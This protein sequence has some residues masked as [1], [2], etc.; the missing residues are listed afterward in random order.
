MAMPPKT[1]RKAAEPSAVSAVVEAPVAPA[2]KRPQKAAAPEPVAP[3]K[4]RR[5]PAVTVIE[6]A[7]PAPLAQ[8]KPPARKRATPL[9]EVAPAPVPA[10]KAAPEKST[11]SRVTSKPAAAKKAASKRSSAAPL[12]PAEAAVEAAPPAPERASATAKAA[13]P[14]KLA[15][16]ATSTDEGGR[17]K[18]ATRPASKAASKSAKKPPVK[19]AVKA[20]AKSAAMPPQPAVEADEPESAFI[21]TADPGE[22]LFGAFGMQDRQS[23]QEVQV[24]LRGAA[25]GDYHCSC[26]AFERSLDARCEHSDFLFESL[27]QGG[28]PIQAMLQQGPLTHYSELW[29]AYGAERRLRWRA[30]LSAPAALQAAAAALLDADRSASAEN[31]QLPQHLLQLAA[32]AGHELRVDPLVWSQLAWASD[33]QQRVQR[34]EP[35]FAEGPEG[36]VLSGLLSQPL[37]AYQ[38]EAALFAVCAGRALLADDLGLSQ[39]APA[40]A[41]LRLWQQCFGLGTALLVAPGDRHPLWRAE[42]Q[43]LLG[44]WPEGVTLLDPSELHPDTRCELLIIDAVQQ[45]TLPLPRLPQAPHGLL[46]ADRELLGEASLE[47]WIDW[48]DIARRGPLARLKA[49]GSQPAKRQQ[50]EALQSVMLSR[51]RRDLDAQLPPT[52]ETKVWLDAGVTLDS[53]ALDAARSQLQRWQKLAYLSHADQLQL[54]QS[55]AQLKQVSTSAAACTAKAEAVVALLPQILPA[56]ASR[57]LVAAQD[58]ATLLPVA[59]KLKALGLSVHAVL[60]SQ[61]QAERLAALE[62]WRGEQGQVLLASDAAC[63]GLNLEQDEAALIHADLPWNPGQR[64]QR[65]QRLAGARKGLP[66][67]QLLIANGLD[68]GL[69]QAQ[70][71]HAELPAGM[72]DASPGAQPFVEV[73]ELGRFMCAVERAL[74]GPSSDA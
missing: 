52:L 37:P 27:K 32:H 12:K 1:R 14:A 49:L 72:L 62:G 48:L 40:L 55:M 46:L 68:A 59:E 39:R 31:S 63:V 24:Q 22:T 73:S 54:M 50:R 41:A 53:G 64:L 16:A 47:A 51:R 66:V 13:K 38:W 44:A 60:L 2:R 7:A 21:W 58:D 65:E 26:A 3:A 61:P 5:K 56:A 9:A 67:W 70:H 69:L 34:L 29:L 4:P 11:K 28:E 8:A 6:P 36:A 33:A 20:K 35:V 10:A 30:G 71:G 42:A 18:P 74:A 19:P 23:Q 17:V 57:V 25:S 15:K 45:W 43:R